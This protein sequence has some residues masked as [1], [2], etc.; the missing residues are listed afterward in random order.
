MRTFDR[1]IVE[2]TVGTAG[3]LGRTWGAIDPAHPT[4]PVTRIHALAHSYSS[5]KPDNAEAT[6]YN[7]SDESLGYL[8]QPAQ[9]MIIRAGVG[10]AGQIFAG[11]IS[12]RGIT[13]EFSGSDWITRIT[14]AEGRRTFREAK[15]SASYPAGITRAT[16]LQDIARALGV[17]VAYLGALP[18]LTFAT[19]WAFVG[20]ARDAL[21][22]LL[23][24]PV[25]A[26]W[27][28]QHG[29]LYILA[30]GEALPENAPLLTPSTGLVG[31]PKRTDKGADFDSLFNPQLRAGGPAV[32][33][34]KWVSGTYKLDARSHDVDNGGSP[35]LTR[36]KGV[37][38]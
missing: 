9:V 19:G 33:K 6:L 14:A 12:R 24:T 38:V 27:T 15:F 23:Q 3:A 22:E 8:E 2:V 29:A 21:T 30:P 34:S 13:T 1:R 25:G 10:I 31:S 28:I 11:D 18:A 32:V 7:L 5:S 26:W 16:I 36:C 20:R 17:P 37:T 35:W 4:K